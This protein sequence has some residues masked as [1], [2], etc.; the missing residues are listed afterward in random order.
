MRGGGRGRFFRNEGGGEGQKKHGGRGAALTLRTR[1]DTK[2]WGLGIG[3]NEIDTT[4]SY[5]E[6]DEAD[7]LEILVT[8]LS[9]R[10]TA[11]PR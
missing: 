1:S 6:R 9:S 7:S 5:F 2:M 4:L 3:I 8:P 10:L 11:L